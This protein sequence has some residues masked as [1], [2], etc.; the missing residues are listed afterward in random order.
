MPLPG[1]LQSSFQFRISFKTSYNLELIKAY[2][3]IDLLLFSYLFR[4]INYFITVFFKLLPVETYSETA[5]RI[6]TQLN[7]WNDVPEELFRIPYPFFPS[8]G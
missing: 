5:Y 8:G 4:K 1:S 7:L 2:Y 6:R 3:Q